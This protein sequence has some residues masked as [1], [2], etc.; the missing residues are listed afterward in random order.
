[1]NGGEH[2]AS[3]RSSGSSGPG[4]R[5]DSIGAVGEGVRGIED[6]PAAVAPEWF[7]IWCGATSLN[8][9]AHASS[10]RW[11]WSGPLQPVTEDGGLFR[12]QILD[13]VAK[14][15]LEREWEDQQEEIWPKHGARPV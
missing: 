3:H 8:P 15:R 11:S 1:M 2:E 14:A 13:V 7:C 9:C 10:Y 12:D 5:D 4:S 6:A